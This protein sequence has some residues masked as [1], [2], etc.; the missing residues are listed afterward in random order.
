MER[1]T[2]QKRAEG[3]AMQHTLE[4]NVSTVSSPWQQTW[5]VIYSAA[6]EPLP[7]VRVTA[8]SGAVE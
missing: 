8:K 7:W 5:P 3:Q 2:K 1:S 4:S 6:T